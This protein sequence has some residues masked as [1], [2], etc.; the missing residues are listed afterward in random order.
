MRRAW[1]ARTVCD[2]DL[3]LDL[4]YSDAGFLWATVPAAELAADDFCHLR[5]DGESS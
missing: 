3:D 1:G 2:S 4:L 5:C